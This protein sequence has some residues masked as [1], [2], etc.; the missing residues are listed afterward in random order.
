MPIDLNMLQ[1]ISDDF[2]VFAKSYMDE[3]LKQGILVGKPFGGVALNLR[4]AHS[5]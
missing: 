3:K 1:N 5:T 2:L 4:L